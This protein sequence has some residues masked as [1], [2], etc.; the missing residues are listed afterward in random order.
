M[1]MP[2]VPVLDIM[3]RSMANLEFVEA[4]AGS[5]GPYEVTQLVNTF[6]SALAHPFEAM[7]DDLIALPLSEAARLGWPPIT[8]ERP[9]DRDP[10]S[11]GDFIRLLRNGFAHGNIEFLGDRKGQIVA[12]RIWNTDPRS[13]SR[14]WGTILPVADIRRL[15]ELFVDLVE[16]R[17]PNVSRYDEGAA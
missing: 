9:S 8:K 5:N 2:T 14:N 16:R 6:L 10:A 1:G 11:L 4:Q 7:R 17:Y 12:L 15:L 13:H 3:R